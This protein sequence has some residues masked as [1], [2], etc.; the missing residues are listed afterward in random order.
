[1]NGHS[2]AMQLTGHDLSHGGI[3]LQHSAAEGR[4]QRL[5]S[6]VDQGD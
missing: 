1:M 4:G 3:E 6:T 5:R 2:G